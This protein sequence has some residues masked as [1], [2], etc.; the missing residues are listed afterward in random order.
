MDLSLVQ[1]SIPLEGLWAAINMPLK[2]TLS[3]G[4]FELPGCYKHQFQFS[5]LVDGMQPCICRI[6]DL[7][8]VP[9]CIEV[10]GAL[11]PIMFGM[12]GLLRLDLKI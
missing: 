2:L 7:L 11:W 1:A 3:C 9:F 5:W 4:K 12:S 10:R 8:H 6:E